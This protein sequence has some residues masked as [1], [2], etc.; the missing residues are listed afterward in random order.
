[1][2]KDFSP[3]CPV[4]SG[5]DQ[6]LLAHGGGGKMMRDLIEKRFRPVFGGTELSRDH[7]GAVWDQEGGR[8]AFT[9]DSY[10]VT[11]RVFPGGDLGKLAIW[12]TVNDLAMCG[13]VTGRISVALILEEGLALGELDEMIQ[14]MALA[15]QEAEV[16]VVTGDTKVV[17]RDHGD[18]IYITTSGV[19]PVTYGPVIGPESI[20]PGDQIILSGDVGRH[21]MAIMAVREGLELGV[22]IESDCAPL[23]QV[24]ASLLDGG[25]KVHCLRDLTR[26]GLAGALLELAEKGEWTFHIKE[27]EISVGDQVRGACEI[28]GLDPFYVANEGRF[29][30]IVDPDSVEEA[31]SSLRSHPPAKQAR[32][33]GEVGESLP[34][35]QVQVESPL[36][37]RRILTYLS[38]EP[39]PRIC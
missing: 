6:I 35:G 31:L 19:G 14:S 28:L 15:A 34:G 10:V 22:P 33:I 11:P 13:A 3:T 17:E 38:G 16:E 2:T 24:V 37:T 30:A 36:G 27:E 1:M 18:G 21:G 25:S 23:N 12:G 4:P 9:T 5:G 32:V 29:I 39:L 7:D 20:S 26:G 8:L